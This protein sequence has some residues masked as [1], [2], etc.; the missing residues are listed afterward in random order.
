MKYQFLSFFCS[1]N[2]KW[3][4]K[5]VCFQPKT[6]KGMQFSEWGDSDLSS[7][8]WGDCGKLSEIKFMGRPHCWGFINEQHEKREIK[9]ITINALKQR[10][11][12]VHEWILNN[13]T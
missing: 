6:T 7:V 11:D 10:F 9:G 13:F 2:W 8:W 12:F 5:L 4:I 1:V 3:N